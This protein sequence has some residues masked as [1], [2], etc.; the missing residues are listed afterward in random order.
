MSEPSERAERILDV[1]VQ[2]ARARQHIGGLALVGSRARGIARPDSDI[3]LVLLVADPETFR[4]DASWVGSINW[5][6]AGV[7]AAQ[8]WRDEDY[9]NV[10]SRRVW[11]DRGV[12]LEISFAPL[13]WACIAPL[14]AG[15]RRV[16]ADGCRI[17]D[18]PD[19]SLDRL[20]RAVNGVTELGT[21]A[22]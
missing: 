4:S 22:P 5:S 20:C 1:I 8:E 14:D 19:G 17:L 21:P 9:G 15:T 18:D 12:E 6:A 13:S 2:W 3:D 11:L 7:R 10:W 16:I